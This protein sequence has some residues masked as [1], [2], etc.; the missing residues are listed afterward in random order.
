MAGQIF[1]DQKYTLNLNTGMPLAD[2]EDVQIAYRKPGG[3]EGTWDATGAG[4]IATHTVLDTENDTAGTWYFHAYIKLSGETT[5][6]PGNR[7]SLRVLELF[8]D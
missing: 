1:K 6:T 8:Q 4:E 5:Y 3:T 7:V 2:A